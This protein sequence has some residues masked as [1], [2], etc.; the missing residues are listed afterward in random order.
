MSVYHL[1][2]WFLH[3]YD[4]NIIRLYLSWEVALFN[5]L[6]DDN[7]FVVK[8]TDGI[9]LYSHPS[10]SMSKLVKIPRVSYNE[11]PPKISG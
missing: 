2:N 4:I 9:S 8:L 11:R 1:Y 6:S 5:S 3:T 7:Y 10:A